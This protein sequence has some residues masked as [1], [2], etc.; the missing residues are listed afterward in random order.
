MKKLL[1]LWVFLGAIV[2]FAHAQDGESNCNDNIDN[3]G[4]GLVDCRDCPGKVCEICNDGIDNDGDGFID[5]YDK[6]CSLDA[7]CNGFFIGKDLLCEARPSSFPQFA[8]T[9]D[10]R[11][12]TEV[13]Q[14]SGKLLVG[15]VDGDGVPEIVS[16]YRNKDNEGAN[17]FISKISILSSPT[18]GG[19]ET[20]TKASR[21]TKADGVYLQ[22][23]GDFAMADVDRDGDAEIFVVSGRRTNPKTWALMAYTYN[24]NTKAIDKFWAAPVSVP[25]DPGNIGLAD[26]DG[27]G[28]V[29][30]Y[31]RDRIFDAHTGVEMGKGNN[32]NGEEWRR[33]SSGSTAA[34]VLDDSK[35]TDC[36]GLELIA[37]CRIYSVS[38]DRSATPTATVTK[39]RERSEYFTRT[40]LNNDNSTSV[41]DFDLDGYLDVVA[42]GSSGSNDNNTTIFFWSLYKGNATPAAVNQGT[43]KTFMDNDAYTNGWKNGAGRVNIADIDGD[44]KLN[45][46]YVSGKYLYALKEGTSSLEQVWRQ[47]V[48]EETS[49]VTG[50]TLFDF[51]ADGT[52]E[53]VYRD[54]NNLYIF[55]SRFPEVNGVPDYTQNSTVSASPGITC[56][57]RTYREYPIVADLDGDGSTEICVTCATNETSA[58]ASLDLYSGARVRVFKS[59]NEPWVPARKVW[60]QHGYFVV[61]VNDNLTIPTNQQLH[62]KVFAH[63]VVCL[64]GRDSRPLNSFLN[65]APFQNSQGCPSFAAPNLS[66]SKGANKPVNLTIVPPTCPEKDFKVSLTVYNTGDVPLT[67]SVP[68]SFY[69]GDPQS[70]AKT[71]VKLKQVNLEFINVAPGDSVELKNEIVTGNGSNFTLF[72]AVNND[73]VN[74]DGSTLPID[75]PNTNFLEC[76]YA[77]NIF[78]M[79]VAPVPADLGVELIKDNIVCSDGSTDPFPDGQ[80][81]AYVIDKNNNNV[82]QNFTFIW[83]NGDFVNNPPNYSNNPNDYS[84]P[85]YTGLAKGTYTVYARHNTLGCGS[86]EMKIEID[87]APSPPPTVEIKPADIQN[88]NSCKTDNGKLTATVTGGSGIF[89]IQWLDG[90]DPNIILGNGPS[91]SGLGGGNYT[92]VVYDSVTGCSDLFNQSLI[93]P[94]APTVTADSKDSDCSTTPVGEAFVTN[95]TANTT[96]LWFDGDAATWFSVSKYPYNETLPPADFQGVSYE[97]LTGGKY[98][99]IAFDNSTQCISLPVVREVKQTTPPPVSISGVTDQTSCGTTAADYNGAVTASVNGGTANYTFEWFKGQNTTG[100]PFLKHISVNTSMASKLTSGLYSVKVTDQTTKCFTIID[101][102]QIKNK[103]STYEVTLT[104]THKTVCTSDGKMDATVLVDGVADS[105]PSKYTFF[106]YKGQSQKPSVDYPAVTVHLLDDIEPGFY[107]VYA[108]HNTLKCET[109]IVKDE[110]MNLVP[111][112]NLAFEADVPPSTCTDK[113]SITFKFSPTD[114][115]YQPSDY[116]TKWFYGTDTTN[117]SKLITEYITDSLRNDVGP[118]MISHIDSL[119]VGTYTF[120]VVNPATGCAETLSHSLKYVDAPEVVVTPTHVTACDPTNL[121]GTNGSFKIDLEVK[122]NTKDASHYDLYVYQGNYPANSPSSPPPA[123]FV[124]DHKIT[125]TSA[126]TYT[127]YTTQPYGIGNYTIVVYDHIISCPTEA[128]AKIDDKVIYPSVAKETFEDSYCNITKTDGNGSVRIIDPVTKSLLPVADYDF[129]WSSNAAIIPALNNQNEAIN[130]LRDGVYTIE[131]TDKVTSCMT[132]IEAT[133]ISNEMMIA[134]KAT[135]TDVFNCSTDGFTPATD[136]TAEVIEIETTEKGTSSPYEGPTFPANYTFLWSDLASTTTYKVIN[137]DTGFH[138]VKVTDAVTECY[139]EKSVEVLDKTKNTVFVDLVDFKKDEYCINPLKGRLK[140]HAVGPGSSYSYSWTNDHDLSYTATTE[141]ILNLTEGIKYMI[142]V[143]NLDNQCIA[144]DTFLMEKL[145][146]PIPVITSKMDL[147]YC[148]PYNGRIQASVVDNHAPVDYQFLWTFHDITKNKN[149]VNKD[150]TNIIN[151]LGKTEGIFVRVIDNENPTDCFTDLIPVDDVRDLRMYPTVI[152]TEVDPVTNCTN[153]FNGIASAFVENEDNSLYSFNWYEG[154]SVTPHPAFAGVQFGNLSSAI[155]TVQAVN[156]FTGCTGTAQIEIS[157]QPISVPIPAIEIL[158]QITN[159]SVGNNAGDNGALAATVNGEIAG[160]TFDWYNGQNEKTAADF[161]GD[162]YTNL[163]TGFYSV[164]ATDDE[165]G[166]RSPLIYEQL[167]FQPRF[168]DFDFAVVNATCADPNLKNGQPNGEAALIL[169]SDVEVGKIEWE[170]IETGE[171]FTETNIENALPGKYIVTVTS[172]LNCFTQKQMEIGTEVHAFNGVSRNGDGYND[173]FFINCIENFPNNHVK[174]FNRAGTL[175]YEAN[176]YNNADTYF[177][178]RSNKGVSLMGTNLPDGTYF[179]VIDKKDGSK[180]VA[181]YLEV[182]N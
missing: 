38:I 55:T 128:P 82:T 16:I 42:V 56:R 84:G 86:E 180:P 139:T 155:Y 75:F 1:L 12:P 99:V 160:Y 129:E 125:G 168:P 60:N 173:I 71:A 149:V 17:D 100:T 91:L 29:E 121:P 147:T 162:T 39:V 48:A 66:L 127:Y 170:H 92:V 45:L 34:D 120:L 156:Y 103:I 9:E 72:V 67:G 112:L 130:L 2:A 179:Y 159:C 118:D 97:N 111:A 7:A 28:M 109:N 114:N 80:A 105:D 25:T 171:Y 133:V 73:G 81:K 161:I 143:K 140:V 46:V 21:L 58:G 19:G 132:S 26:F 10:F 104:P 62:H 74:N 53:I 49:G 123:G 89:G 126:S 57:S 145:V 150:T 96:Y 68:I 35:C 44:G 23:E 40:G 178:G 117:I 22:H 30:L 33:E 113:G 151:G 61:N 50:C 163:I 27:D 146:N 51:N 177:D 142:E 3:D 152:A 41:A 87:D 70:P 119:W 115:S 77:D 47:L 65:Q 52:S 4:D 164:I 59:A 172:S 107:T 122:D 93:A 134:V 157:N 6:E 83:S 37:G 95:V 76:N 144:R 79:S 106:W 176:G 63:N 98:S 15:D 138:S 166:C 24:K 20:T 141:E 11:S 14:H 124:E 131:V 181:G 167:L 108:R 110:I 54:E 101:T 137:L 88:P 94:V 31:A 85:I 43:L 64:D 13:T 78:S 116:T 5:C 32:L 175:V 135:P 158:S 136:A 154:G 90:D 36:Q 18:N 165:T 69:R 102:I 148:A 174:I 182:V 169:L 8:L 153:P